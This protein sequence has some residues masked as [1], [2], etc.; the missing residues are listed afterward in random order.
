MFLLIINLEIL[1][2]GFQKE[3]SIVVL[4]MFDSSVT[5]MRP[6]EEILT[7]IYLL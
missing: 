7:R 6:R 5:I 3:S 2:F 1:D 4:A